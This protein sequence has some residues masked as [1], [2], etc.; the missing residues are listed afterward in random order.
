MLTK[1]L[2][3]GGGH[4]LSGNPKEPDLST[5]SLFK[6]S[7]CVACHRV[8]QQHIG[9]SMVAVADRYASDPNALGII[10]HS[11]KLGGTGKWGMNE[12]P[13]QVQLREE[14][15]KRLASWIVEIRKSPKIDQWTKDEEIELANNPQT[16]FD[17]TTSPEIQLP[18]KREGT[19]VKVGDQ[20][21]IFRTYL[22]GA[23]SRAIAV[24]L[25]GNRSYAF[26]ATQCRLLYFWKG[27]FLDFKKSWTGHGG[28]YSHLLGPK[29]FTAPPH[30]PLR[31]G[32]SEE[33]QKV[34]F[35]GYRMVH[36][37]PEFLYRIDQ[38]DVRH[39][40]TFQPEEDII[41]Q[42]FFLSKTENKIFF[43]GG[44]NSQNLS[45]EDGEWRGNALL[46][47]PVKQEAFTIFTQVIR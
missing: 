16:L 18:E 32:N 2:L 4:Y 7:G 1:V 47:D 29:I 3:L 17:Q 27:G 23:S 40:I 20:P 30:F 22:P 10:L 6:S 46:I 26:D 39:Q 24:G 38:L 28:W 43:I 41:V 21:V 37:Q 15:H 9:P 11:L 14:T 35:N 8:T 13:P 25:P 36:G 31:L 34:K 45:S 44:E 42:K 19:V 33:I 5:D 12:M